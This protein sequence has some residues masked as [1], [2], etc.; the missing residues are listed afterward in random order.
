MLAYAVWW[1]PATLISAGCAAS[2]SRPP[3]ETEKSQFGRKLHTS[4]VRTTTPTLSG[5]LAFVGTT[6]TSESCGKTRRLRM[7]SS[8]ASCRYGCPSRKST[9]R[10][11]T[12]LRDVV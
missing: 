7:V 1:S 8:S 10:S 12:N 6:R 9:S 4:L 5:V 11:M 3:F 2:S